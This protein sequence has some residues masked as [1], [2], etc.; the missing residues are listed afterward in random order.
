MNTIIPIKNLNR[1]FRGG[2]I[3]ALSALWIASTWVQGGLQSHQWLLD[4]D[5]NPAPGTG[6]TVEVTVGTGGVG[7]QSSLEGL[8]GA[9]GF[10]DLGQSGQIR[11]ALTKQVIGPAE[12]TVRLSQ[13]YDGVLFGDV[14]VSVPNAS[15][16]LVQFLSTEGPRKPETD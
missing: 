14:L 1:G 8:P 2:V 7:W 13:W 5:A 4:D 11:V 3:L 12:I 9:T 6:G 15:Q 10:W 16:R